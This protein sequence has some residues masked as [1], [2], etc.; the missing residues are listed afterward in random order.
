MMP[1]L[2]VLTAL[3][4]IAGITFAMQPASAQGTTPAEKHLLLE[5]VTLPASKDN[6]LY[7]PFDG[8]SE[9][10][11][12]L[13]QHLPVGLIAMGKLRRALYAFDIAGNL[14]A[15]AIIVDV[16]LQLSIIR[17]PQLMTVTA[18]LHKVT[19]DWGESTSKATG[20][21]GQ[22]APAGVDD[23]TWSYRFYS[24]TLWTTAG[25]DFVSIASAQTEVVGVGDYIWS[26]PQM[27]A[28]VQS[29]LNDPASNFGWVVR[30][31]EII[32]QRAKRFET[33][34]SVKI[35]QRPKLIITYQLPN[36]TPQPTE[37]PTATATS[38][39]TTK[40]SATATKTKIAAATPT[41]KATEITPAAPTITRTPK[42]PTA[43]PVPTK[44]IYLPVVQR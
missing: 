31:E 16:S 12:A 6:G 35:E 13:G 43:T 24:H 9:M 17:A 11:N 39:A 10:S 23:T 30:G 27:V 4:W 19:S 38:T 37:T 20:A 32:P 41:A 26:S 7:E 42:P 21:E 8:S 5:Q 18:S 33:R 1:A 22:G 36:Q 25:G 14:P 15:D 3:L 34:E 44:V 2:C 29:W 40:P 28:D